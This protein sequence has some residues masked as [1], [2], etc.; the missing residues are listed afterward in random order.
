MMLLEW[1]VSSSLL[2][3]S[4]WTKNACRVQSFLLVWVNTTYVNVNVLQVTISD[5]RNISSSFSDE[6]RPLRT[7]RCHERCHSIWGHQHAVK[8]FDVPFHV[9]P[10]V[11][12]MYEHYEQGVGSGGPL[13][14]WRGNVRERQLTWWA[15][16]KCGRR[17]RRLGEVIFKGFCTL[18]CTLD[19]ETIR[20]LV[21]ALY[22][23]GWWKLVEGNSGHWCFVSWAEYRPIRGD[24]SPVCKIPMM[25][26]LQETWE[27][28]RGCT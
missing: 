9:E 23:D 26:V 16:I 14:S 11:R 25:P 21:N 28:V 19:I 15:G 6:S 3:F 7:I 22:G 10:I 4:L 17:G 13:Q 24:A 27:A 1:A 5:V 12:A 2:L 8:N 18:V 20:T